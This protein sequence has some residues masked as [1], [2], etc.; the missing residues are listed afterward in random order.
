MARQYN[1]KWIVLDGKFWMDP[2]KQQELLD[3]PL[4]GAAFFYQEELTYWSP[5]L[6]TPN[7]WQVWSFGF[8]TFFFGVMKKELS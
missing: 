2:V 7:S 3:P 1:N 5:R 6:P 4:D 8:Q